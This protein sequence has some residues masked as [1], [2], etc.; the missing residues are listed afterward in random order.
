MASEPD[1]RRKLRYPSPLVKSLF[2]HGLITLILISRQVE[3]ANRNRQAD[4]LGSHKI[5][6]MQQKIFSNCEKFA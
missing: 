4:V 2:I 1:H 3:S 6:D 5:E